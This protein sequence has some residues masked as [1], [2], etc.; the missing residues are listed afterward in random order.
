MTWKSYAA[1]SGATVLAGWLA[2]S[3]PANAPVSSAPV[4]RRALAAQP[5]AESDIQEQAARLQTRVRQ[6]IA[7]RD[8][9]RNPFRFGARQ[10]AA[11]TASAGSPVVTLPVETAPPVPQA[12]AVSL[13]GIAE[14][15]VGE[16]TERTAILSTPSNVLLV[17]EGDEVMGQYRVTKIDAGAVELLKLADGTTLRL[18]LKTSSAQ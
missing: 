18:A 10:A 1:V 17:R 8:P 9:E 11:R 7:Y 6:E 15:Q 16:R 2:S 14:D 5:A 3:P 12:P 4:Q 13:A